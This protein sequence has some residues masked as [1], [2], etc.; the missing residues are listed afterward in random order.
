MRRNKIG[1]SQTCRPLHARDT[2]S[3]KRQ[4]D[5]RVEKQLSALR[6]LFRRPNTYQTMNQ[7]NIINLVRPNTPWNWRVDIPHSSYTTSNTAN[8]HSE[9]CPT[10]AQDFSKGHEQKNLHWCSLMHNRRGPLKT[11]RIDFSKSLLAGLIQRVRRRA[12]FMPCET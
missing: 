7:E 6:I 5:P 1:H 8:A 10:C 12:I 3:I 11:M 9:Q 2:Q 4:S